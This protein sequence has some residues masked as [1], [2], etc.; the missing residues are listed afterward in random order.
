MT[1]HGQTVGYVRVSST[2]QNLA[3]QL[4]LIGPVDRLFQDKV[5]GGSRANRIG[6]AECLAYIRAGDTIRVASMDRLA[7]SLIDL[8]QLVDEILAE[9][10]TIHFVKEGQ[11]YSGARDDSMSRL[12]L[13]ILGAFAEF[14]RNLIRERQAEGI[15]IAKAAGKYRG[16]AKLLNPEQLN[17]A[18]ELVD[19]GVP[20]TRVAGRLGVHRSTLYRALAQQASAGV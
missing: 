12:M 13:Q 16:R 17:L 7:R 10:A 20:K 18:R 14:E 3:R 8:Q 19:Q 1:P 2:E 15:R 4:D 11:T 6:L 5:S 9:G